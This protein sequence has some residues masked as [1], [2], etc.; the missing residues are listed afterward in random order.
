MTL[1]SKRR[2]VTDTQKQI[3]AIIEH[4]GGLTS[5]ITDHGALTGLEDDDHTQ[6]QLVSRLPE[7]ARVY[8]SAIITVPHMTHT[9]LPMN[10]ERWDNDD[11]HST[12]TNNT[13]LVCKTA[14][15]YLIWGNARFAGNASGIRRL[16]IRLNGSTFIAASTVHSVDASV[17]TYVDVSTVF[18]LSADGYVELVA[19]QTSG[20][21]LNVEV[22]SANSPEF[23]MVRIA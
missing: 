15:I 21:D 8:N 5:G 23:A 2:A 1:P 9:P 3:N 14:G 10:S 4:V 22:N 16:S 11:C 19:Y 17:V 12:S 20:G 18:Q 6:Y 13:R 7:G